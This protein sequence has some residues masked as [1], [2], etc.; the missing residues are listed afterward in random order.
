MVVIEPYV[1]RKVEF[2]CVVLDTDQ[3]PV[4]LLPTEIEMVDEDADVRAAE[5][6]IQEYRRQVQNKQT[7]KQQEYI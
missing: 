7:N 3:G 2:T 1:S 5:K 4:A 6:R